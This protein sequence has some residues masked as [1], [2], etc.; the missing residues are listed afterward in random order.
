M[1]QRQRSDESGAEIYETPDTSRAETYSTPQ[2]RTVQRT[3]TAPAPRYDLDVVTPTDRIRWGPVLAGLFAALATL[4]TL[5]MLGIAIGATAFDPGDTARGFGL[6]AGIWG[7]ISTLLAFL[8][9]G[10][11]A[12]RTAAL[13]GRSSGMLN[14]AM[15]WFVAIPLL[16]YLLSS[17]VSSLIG[18]AG[19]AAGTA[20]AAVA[21]AAGAA[22]NDP[23]LQATAQAGAAGATG[24]IQATAQALGAAAQD[25]QNQQA[26]A[27]AVSRGA[28]GA[29]L[30]LG[31]AAAA[32]IGGGI[33]GARREEDEQIGAGAT[34]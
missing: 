23:A 25:P 32:S 18:T 27:D 1:T 34:V 13:P 33:L 4:A 21:P 11:M 28:W 12:A 10:W 5:T 24:A 30:S 29:L 9:G 8:V 31:L 3:A 22:A 20:A 26:A 17:G 6:G 7:A 2:A 15:V 14:G 19:R 16:V